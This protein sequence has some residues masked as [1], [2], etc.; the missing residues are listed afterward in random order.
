MTTSNTESSSSSSSGD[1][2]KTTDASGNTGNQPADANGNK[3]ATTTTTTIATT[4]TN[5]FPDIV[6]IL[7]NSNAMLVIWFL[8]VY[9]VIYL[10]LNVLRG[11]A[12]AQQGIVKWFDVAVLMSALV[13]MVVV[14]FSQ[15]DSDKAAMLTAFYEDI[16]SYLNTPTSAFSIGF[17]IVVLYVF[18]YVVGLPMDSSKPVSIAI[19]ENAAWLLLLA[20]LASTFFSAFLQTTLTD[21]LDRLF[22]RTAPAASDEAADKATATDS[23][24]NKE[25][26]FNIANNM[27]T[28][29]D[30]QSVCASFGGRLATYDEVE[31]AYN[32]GGEWCNYGWSDG[33]AAYFPTQKD[34][35]NKLQKNESTKHAC[36]RPGVNGGYIANPNVRFGVNCFGVKPAPSESDLAE[37]NK[38]GNNVPK[39]PEDALREKKIQFW[40]DNRDKLLDI[41]AYNSRKWSQF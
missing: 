19:V 35:W 6:T 34:T 5:A 37:L 22:N 26:V 27:Y 10:L 40:K 13:Y 8:L 33:Q 30:A 16:K 39:T 1:D 25:E 28:Y 12:G 15:S 17:F 14:F 20:V 21:L 36:G 9:F 2:K 32:N 24:G 23:S 7:N 31:T 38:P 3:A 4:N 41:N 11:S 29:D 18:V